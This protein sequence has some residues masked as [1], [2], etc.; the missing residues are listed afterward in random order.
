MKQDSYT[1]LNI[2]HNA[3]LNFNVN[4][5]AVKIHLLYEPEY[6]TLYIGNLMEHRT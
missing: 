3:R 6:V 5:L 4:S 2:L 1:L